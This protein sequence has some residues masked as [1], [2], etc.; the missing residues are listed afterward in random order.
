MKCQ[1]KMAFC[2]H[3]NAD[4]VVYDITNKSQPYVIRKMHRNHKLIKKYSS[5]QIT[6]GKGLYVMLS[7]PTARLFNCGDVHAF[8]A[9]CTCVC[10][11]SRMH[12]PYVH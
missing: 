4:Q 10:A 5:Q 12:D 2:G 1:K 11:C 9:S 3:F 6:V 7:C 8:P